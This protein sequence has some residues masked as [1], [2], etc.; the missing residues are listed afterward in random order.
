MLNVNDIPSKIIFS[1]KKEDEKLSHIEGNWQISDKIWHRGLPGRREAHIVYS[2]AKHFNDFG[3]TVILD[4]GYYCGKKDSNYKLKCDIAMALDSSDLKWLFLEVKTMPFEDR[5]DKLIYA[6]ADV[7]KLI[8]VA[9]ANNRNLPQGIV[10]VGY[11]RIE[12]HSV[13]LK[14]YNAFSEEEHINKWPIHLLDKFELTTKDYYTH[15]IVGI[16]IRKR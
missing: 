5:H 4:D 14:D 7:K 16:W 3:N 10:L 9:K 2:I 1:L 6:S 12:R 15:C 13:L 11:E 8:S